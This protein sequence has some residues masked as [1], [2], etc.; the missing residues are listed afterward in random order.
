MNAAAP[1]PPRSESLL[2]RRPPP[3]N[4]NRRNQSASSAMAPTRT[5]TRS[6]KRM[7]RLPI[8]LISCPITP[9]SCSR[10]SLS[11]RP[12]V[13]AT[14]ACSGSRPVAN[15]FGAVSSMTQTR[16]LGSP[17]ASRISSTTLTYCWN[18]SGGAAARSISR[19]PL[20]AMTSASPAKNEPMLISVATTTAMTT[21]APAEAGRVAD[22]GA[23]ASRGP[24]RRSRRATS[25]V[26]GCARSPDR[27]WS[28][29]GAPPR[30]SAQVVLRSTC[31]TAASDS[32]IWK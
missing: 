13:T 25:S 31:G 30:S 1:P 28:A 9:C 32:A 26:D 7:S 17:P 12:V 3:Q 18:R 20:V 4:V 5:P 19:A 16:G 22:D 21:P 2:L 11:S 29:P 10:S 15:A 14:L 23:E 27:R 24:A 6:V 8:W